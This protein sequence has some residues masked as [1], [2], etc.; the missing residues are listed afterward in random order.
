MAK[1]K[2]LGIDAEAKKVL[3]TLCKETD[4][5][6]KA[7]KKIDKALGENREQ[8]Y[9]NKLPKLIKALTCITKRKTLNTNLN[10]SELKIYSPNK[11]KVVFGL[12][13]N[14]LGYERW[15]T[16]LKSICEGEKYEIFDD[17]NYNILMGVF[18]NEELCIE[19]ANE[20]LSRNRK[21]FLRLVAFF[22]KLPQQDKGITDDNSVRISEEI[23]IYFYKNYNFKSL[24]I[25]GNDIND[26][27]IYIIK[28]NKEASNKD[29]Y[30]HITIYDLICAEKIIENHKD[31]AEAIYNN[32]V[33]VKENI[34]LN[35]TTNDF[36]FDM[37][38]PIEAL[39]KL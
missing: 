3:T 32:E 28:D 37:I 25:D 24:E 18:K 17:D 13:N 23:V 36:V 21:N 2:E 39:E 26:T 35:K 19:I 16:Q 7:F 4:D 5:I 11:Q 15:G 8:T 22:R 33:K 31:I 6:N 14:G 9:L 27:I 38:K 34:K 12:N 29:R 30:N 1:I 10:L 20:I